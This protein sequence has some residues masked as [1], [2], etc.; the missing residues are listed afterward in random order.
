[1]GST[2][3][4]M[5]IINAI[6][7]GIIQGLT[8]FLPVSS[9]GHLSIYQHLTGLSGEGAL[10]FSLMLHVG[11]LVAVVVAFWKT[12]IRMIA[13]FFLMIGDIFKGRFKYSECNEERKAVIMT[14]L[15]L[16][17]LFG[18]YFLK[19]YIAVVSE[20]NDII[21]EGLCFLF[22]SLLLFLATRDNGGEK[23][24]VDMRPR[25]ALVVGVFQ[26][27]AML[28]GVSRSGSTVSSAM[29]L[30]FSKP[31]AVSFSFI[32]GIPV[33]LASAALD[34]KDSLEA[35]LAF[36]WLP[37]IIGMVTAAVVGYLAIILIKWLVMNNHFRIF[38]YYTL[39]L[40]VLVLA[41]GILERV[42]GENITAIVANL[43]GK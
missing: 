27:I 35:G 36:D 40:G 11:T 26:G 16:V 24:A 22:T 28:P 29:F 38:A 13:E 33:I 5:D 3:V 43:F 15:A 10:T 21:I 30:G 34:L 17:P 14:I 20:D 7:Q 25:D 42:Y 18:F 31:F 32:L 1:M 19:D 2:E 8:E 41:A 12:I 6:I 39:V 4:N 37:V 9:S 23:T